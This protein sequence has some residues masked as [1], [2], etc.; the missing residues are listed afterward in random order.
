MSRSH[1]A[2]RC[3][4]SSV[5]S[6][7]SGGTYSEVAGAEATAAA[8]PPPSETRGRLAAAEPPSAASR[9][10]AFCGDAAAER[11]AGDEGRPSCAG[12]II[13]GRAAPDLGPP[14]K[15]KIDAWAILPRGS[16]W[17]GPGGRLCSRARSGGR[18]CAATAD[19]RA[20]V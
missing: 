1:G 4:H 16:G 10:A 18:V 5:R 6:T 7:V 19:L 12:L 20:Q 11:L 3:S 8:E 14:K 17:V 2:C 15:E 13:V 9:L